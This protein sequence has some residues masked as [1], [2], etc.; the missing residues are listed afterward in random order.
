[1][2]PVRSHLAGLLPD[3]F[4]LANNWFLVSDAPERVGFV[5]WEISDVGTFGQGGAATPG[6]AFVGFITDDPLVVA[7]LASVLGTFGRPAPARPPARPA[8]SSP[9]SRSP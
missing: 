2:E 9:C 1:M 6:K 4:R 3:R 5:S 7:E 8:E